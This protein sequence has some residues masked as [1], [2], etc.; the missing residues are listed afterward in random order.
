MYAA[1]PDYDAWRKQD[2]A[3]SLA[4]YEIHELL[5]PHEQKERD[6]LLDVVA[7]S[8]RLLTNLRNS[9]AAKAIEARVTALAQLPHE[10]SVSQRCDW[11]TDVP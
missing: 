3:S 6:E 1:D 11:A 8:K 7:D 5:T 10:V 9:D 2:L 4:A